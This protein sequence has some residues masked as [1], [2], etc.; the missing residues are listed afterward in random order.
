MLGMCCS[1]RPVVCEPRQL[2][3]PRRPDRAPTM[4][5]HVQRT[6]CWGPIG[7]YVQPSASAPSEA[8]EALS[9]EPGSIKATE[10]ILSIVAVNISFI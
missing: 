3:H 9:A 8:N 1:T 7:A 10:T 6:L 2:V 4:F 5:K